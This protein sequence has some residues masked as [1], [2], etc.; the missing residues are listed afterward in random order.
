MP[1]AVLVLSAVV[2]VGKV[3]GV[4][5]G[6]FVAGNGVRLSIQ[7]GMSLAQIG[8]FSFIIAGL[9]ATAGVLRGFFF[10]VAIAVSAITTLLTPFLIRGSSGFAAYRGSQAAPR[11]ANLAALYGSWV[12]ALS[13]TRGRQTNGRVSAASPSS[14]CSTWSSLPPWSSPRRSAGDHV[15]YGLAGHVHPT[16]ARAAVTVSAIVLA[17]P[18]FWGALRTARRLG[19]VLAEGA[20]PR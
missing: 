14:S 13:E 20:F 11:G 2:V 3:L 16:L 15:A 8:E 12:Q 17:L 9:G 5:L 10:P 1:L 18:F 4:S 7:S 6:A 19:L